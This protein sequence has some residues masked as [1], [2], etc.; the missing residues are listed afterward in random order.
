M[1]FSIVMA[2]FNNRKEQTINTLNSIKT[3]Y[4]P[5]E[6]PK[7]D[8]EL[9]IVDDNCEEEHKLNDIINNYPYKIKYIEIRN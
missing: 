1:K 6:K 4:H 2:Y 8:F 9:V 3:L 5:L 7:Y